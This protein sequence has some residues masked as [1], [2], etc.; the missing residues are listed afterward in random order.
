MFAISLI[1]TF[2]FAVASVGSFLGSSYAKRNSYETLLEEKNYIEAI[3]V[4]REDTRAYV[5][6]AERIYSEAVTITDGDATD[7][8]ELSGEN[9]TIGDIKSWFRDETLSK[10]SK[11]H[12]E[13]YAKIE[14]MLGFSMWEKYGGS[15]A[16][17][18]M[19][20]MP[21][22]ERVISVAQSGVAGEYAGLTEK[23]FNLV[24][25]YYAVS[26]FRANRSSLN[27]NEAG[28]KTDELSDVAKFAGI[29]TDAF[30]K[31]PYRAFWNTNVQVLKLLN[32]D[33]QMTQAA[34][35]KTLKKLAYILTENHKNF[36]E[37]VNFEEMEDF[38][39]DF[40]NALNSVPNSE[41]SY[42]TSKEEIKKTI[43]NC[44]P[45]L[46]QLYTDRAVNLEG[47]K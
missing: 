18:M 26:F 25:A 16:D 8:K 44:I 13:D 31:S 17:S 39:R 1:L 21:Y 5:K 45:L 42:V 38:L 35:L 41:E 22:F 27:E 20:A 34:K 47:I 7:N 23:Q 3:E 10:F 2:V 6:L 32:S 14:F 29:D 9:V 12:P 28:D 30:A 37:V 40:K 43:N 19:K 15:E 36:A 46:N 4:D 33:A 11:E 24:K